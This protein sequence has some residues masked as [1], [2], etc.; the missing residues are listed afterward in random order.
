MIPSYD[1]KQEMPLSLSWMAT[2][3]DNLQQATV[4]ASSIFKLMHWMR[5]LTSVLRMLT[6]MSCVTT[7]T[8][9]EDAHL[10]R[11]ETDIIESRVVPLTIY[12]VE[13]T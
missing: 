4:S 3:N 5:A 7:C 10:M 11:Y 9:A 6:R 2:D 12:G 1:I 8:D 13:P